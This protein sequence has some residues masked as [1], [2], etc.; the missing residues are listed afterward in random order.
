[1]VQ[2][3][4]NKYAVPHMLSNYPGEEPYVRI[5]ALD[6]LVRPTARHS[7][8]AQTTKA[9]AIAGHGH[10]TCRTAHAVLSDH[11]APRANLAGM[12]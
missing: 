3:T 4:F 8:T 5:S 9:L 10:A 1:M 12:S 6:Q 2:V 7:C 11:G